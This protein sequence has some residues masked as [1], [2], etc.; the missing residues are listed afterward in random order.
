[1]HLRAPSSLI[2]VAGVPL[3]TLGLGARAAAAQDWTAE[4]AANQFGAGRPSFGYTINPGGEVKDGLVVVNHG[5]AP[6]RLAVRPD[7]AG[8]AA[9]VHP[10]QRDVTVAPGGSAQVP[11]TLTLPKN[12]SPGDYAGRIAG[13]P[14]RL[15]VGGALKPSLAVEDVHVRYGSGVATVTYTIRN[16]G[17]ATLTARQNVSV[18]GPLGRWKREAGAVADSPSLLPRATWKGSAT[19]RDV[20]PA[21]R[22]TATVAL[23]PLLTDEAGSIS[24]LAAVRS[25][26]HGWA[27]PWTV[28][29]G[30]ALVC[31][32]AAAA[33]RLR[34]RARAAH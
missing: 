33:L 16:S 10:D 22:L 11:F 3:A 5:A 24:P 14:I 26:G 17:N 29:A 4:T 7:G 31:G 1:V 18:S 13:I 34:P 2:I 20:K 15:R 32:L 23:T 28:L 8:I 27:I 6:L 9:W 19:V 21:L 25:T 30:L 12:A